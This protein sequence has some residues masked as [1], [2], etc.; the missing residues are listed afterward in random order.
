M[1]KIKQSIADFVEKSGIIDKVEGF[2]NYLSQPENIRK[3]IMMVRDVFA[4]IVD[5]VATV[6]SGIISVLDFFGAISDQKAESAQSFLSGAGDKIRSLGGDFG[7]V[8]VTNSSA[9]NETA[10]GGSTTP[11]ASNKM[12]MPGSPQVYVMVRVDPVTG[13]TVEE[14]V[15]KQYYEATIGKQGK[16]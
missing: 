2:I 1:E 11:I 14:V 10:G 9:K 12:A 15:T 16:Y 6:A 4:Q 7:G 5:I 3:T 8:S 13:K